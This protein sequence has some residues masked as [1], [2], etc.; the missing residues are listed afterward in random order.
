MSWIPT[1]GL[2]LPPAYTAKC[3]VQTAKC[4]L[5]RH[6]LR[7]LTTTVVAVLTTQYKFA[8]I[9]LNRFSCSP[10]Y[11][12]TFLLFKQ[13]TPFSRW[14]WKTFFK[15]LLTLSCLFVEITVDGTLGY[16]HN[17]WKRNRASLKSLLVIFKHSKETK[18]VFWYI[19]LLWSV[20]Y[21]HGRYPSYHQANF[22]P[23]MKLLIRSIVYYI[24]R[25]WK[26]FSGN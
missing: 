3:W 17:L 13:T 5:D 21:L 22:Q 8:N 11:F 26:S 10:K 25:G 18:L 24:W 19:S 2:V 12:I 6:K 1:L 14:F 20:I 9:L 4:S 15:W 23:W 7:I 16:E